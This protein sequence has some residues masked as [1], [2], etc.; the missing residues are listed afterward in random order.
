MDDL[1]LG[2]FLVEEVKSANVLRQLQPLPVHGMEPIVVEIVHA[3]PLQLPIKE[4]GQ[5]LGGLDDKK[6]EFVSEGIGVSGI[7]FRHAL[8][9]GQDRKR[10]V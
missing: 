1:A 2:F 5:G 10:V 6:A 3:A 8:P 4:A 7:A 9:E